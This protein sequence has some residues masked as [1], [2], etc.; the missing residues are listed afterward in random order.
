MSTKT[1]DGIN[2]IA[3]AAANTIEIANN[4]A[5]QVA[6]SSTVKSLDNA[7]A[8]MITQSVE[9]TGDAIAWTK[10]QIPEVIEQL[11]RWKM[12]SSFM[13]FAVWLTILVLIWISAYKFNKRAAS[14]DKGF[15]YFIAFLLSTFFVPALFL[16]TDW[17]YIWIAPKV[18]LLEYA[19]SLIKGNM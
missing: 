1:A 16:S 5:S 3:N 7:L 2:N 8:T 17:L 18:Y 19:A 6:N 9:A 13:W 12:F 4:T 14:A 15:S 11:L 10:G